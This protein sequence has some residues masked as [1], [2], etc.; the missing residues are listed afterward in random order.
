VDERRSVIAARLARFANEWKLIKLVDNPAN[1]GWWV[2]VIA[3]PTLAVVLENGRG[4]QEC[5]APETNSAEQW[6]MASLTKVARLENLLQVTSES[7]KLANGKAAEIKAEVAISQTVDGKKATYLPGVSDLRFSHGDAIYITITNKGDSAVD[8][9]VFLVGGNY[10]IK[11][12]YPDRST[13]Y[14]ARPPAGKSITIGKDVKINAEKSAGIERLLLEQ[15]VFSRS[16]IPA[17]AEE[18]QAVT[19]GHVAECRGNRLL[20][21]IEG[22]GRGRSQVLLDLR[23]HVL[24]RIEVRRVRRQVQQRGT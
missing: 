1:A 22:P 8:L 9:T 13:T 24:D 16:V 5:S 14:L 11:I 2:N 6:V 4:G 12:L 10:G 17:V 23:P 19:G 7:D 20:Q 21:C 18:A 3:D 15:R